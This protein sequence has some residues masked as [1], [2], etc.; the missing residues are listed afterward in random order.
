AA[1]RRRQAGRRGVPNTPDVP[2]GRGVPNDRR[3]GARSSRRLAAWIAAGAVALAASL[4]ALR[5]ESRRRE[6]AALWG[7]VVTG[8]ERVGLPAQRPIA[9][10]AM[11]TP[12]DF[13]GAESCASCHAE[14]SAAWARS[15]HGRAGGAPSAERVIAPFDG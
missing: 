5:A 15:T 1:M 12:D 8:A 10:V 6:S 9:A 7:D 11:P 2:N 3:E 13:A 14:Q 4:V